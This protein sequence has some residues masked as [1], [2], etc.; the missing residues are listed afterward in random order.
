[1]RPWR[2][3][4][5]GNP[6][7]R[8]AVTEAMRLCRELTPEAVETLQKNLKSRNPMAQIAAATKILEFAWGKPAVMDIAGNALPEIIQ[9]L[10]VTQVRAVIVQPPDRDAS[11]PSCN[12]A[13]GHLT[14][15]SEA[16]IAPD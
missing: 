2:P 1:L 15:T 5:S 14:G 11:P 7:G 9:N 3:G 10:I 16:Q 12:G 6:G 13:D 8:P 4:K